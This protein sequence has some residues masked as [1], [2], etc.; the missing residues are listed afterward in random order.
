MDR[1]A[2]PTGVGG[3]GG[4]GVGRDGAECCRTQRLSSPIA[5]SPNQQVTDSWLERS[6]VERS[7]RCQRGSSADAGSSYAEPKGI[8]TLASQERRFKGG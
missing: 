1:Q 2:P 6:E 7:A 5:S 3:V 8:M 4:G